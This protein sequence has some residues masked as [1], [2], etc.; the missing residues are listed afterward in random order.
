MRNIKGKYIVFEKFYE[1]INKMLF[2][3]LANEQEITNSE[4]FIEIKLEKN[5]VFLQNK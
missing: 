5:F 2:F 4:E 1:I 3:S